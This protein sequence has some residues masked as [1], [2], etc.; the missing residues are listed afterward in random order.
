MVTSTA[1]VLACDSGL[2]VYWGQN[3]YGVTNSADKAKWEG[4]LSDYCNS[5]LV[6]TVVISFLNVFGQGKA[7]SANLGNHCDQSNVY[8]G[9]QM[10]DCST[11]QDDVQTCRKKGVKVELAMGGAA[12]SYGF[13][14]DADGAQFAEEL[15]DLAFSG[16]GDIRPFGPDGVDGVNLDIEDGNPMGY[17]GF[18]N[19]LRELSPNVHISAAPQCVYPDASLGNVLK[20]APVDAVYVQ[21]YN[22]A[23]GVQAYVKNAKVYLGVPGSPSAAG[24]GY[25]DPGKLDEITKS[26]A[27]EYSD[28]FGGIMLWDAS[29]AFGNEIN[30]KS[31]AQS[32]S[33]T[34]KQV[35]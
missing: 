35:C 28:V 20:S 7:A 19:R 5:G 27:K 17:T 33:E 30:G 23:C 18:V 9:T 15:N 16:K 14:S 29:Q 21:F 8:S 3:S 6:G 25:I 12:G 31:Y 2:V 4:R 11:V 10:P 34:L 26:L 24:S 22:N 32:T 13:T 1:T